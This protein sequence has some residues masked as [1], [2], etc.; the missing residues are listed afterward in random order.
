MWRRLS[1]YFCLLDS[2]EWISNGFAGHFLVLF[3][4]LLSTC[5]SHYKGHFSP[6]KNVFFFCGEKKNFLWYRKNTAKERRPG[7]RCL[8]ITEKSHSILRAKR[9]TFTFW[10]DKN[11]LKMPKMV[12]F[13]EFLKTWSL[14]SK[15]VT[16][17]VCFNRTKIGGK[18]QN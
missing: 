7:S 13:D 4:I 10:V 2:I 1:P 11:S 14:R 18:C 12:H 6:L 16:R 5:F 9:A 15:S 8:K 3:M 17:Q